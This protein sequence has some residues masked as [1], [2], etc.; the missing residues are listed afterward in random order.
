MYKSI[1]NNTF[2]PIRCVI[3][4]IW[5]G[6]VCGGGG[7]VCGVCVCVCVCVCVL[8]LD[9]LLSIIC[10]VVQI[11]I[12]IHFV[13]CFKPKIRKFSTKKKKKKKNIYIYIYIFEFLNGCYIYLS[14][15]CT[16]YYK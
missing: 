3:L 2:K 5:G 6:R 14:P 13:W 9:K 1:Y 4:W 12:I 11:L 16:S 8:S 7:S 10:G 15:N